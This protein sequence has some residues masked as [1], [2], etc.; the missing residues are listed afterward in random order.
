M[1]FILWTFVRATR[2]ESSQLPSQSRRDDA[3]LRDASAN[4]GRPRAL[5]QVRGGCVGFF[6]TPQIAGCG[7]FPGQRPTVG[8]PPT[9]PALDL[10]PTPVPD[11]NSVRERF[12][13][14]ECLPTQMALRV[15]CLTRTTGPGSGDAPEPGT[16]YS[17]V[18]CRIVPEAPFRNHNRA[19]A[20]F[21]SLRCSLDNGLA[22][23]R[24]A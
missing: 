24:V 2:I 5:R 21:C 6:V 8:G 18:C 12:A 10:S 11:R 9:T 23:A 16:G 20:T 14:G 17:V 4:R 13:P 22:L 7:R 1:E 15:A 19:S 3:R